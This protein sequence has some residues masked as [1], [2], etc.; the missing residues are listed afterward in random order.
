MLIVLLSECKA[1]LPCNCGCIGV[2]KW[3]YGNVKWLVLS[4]RLWYIMLVN[5]V[6]HCVLAR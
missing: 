2:L 4:P 1:L 6:T 5:V 3:L